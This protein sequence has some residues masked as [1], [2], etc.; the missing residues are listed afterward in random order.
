M[1]LPS[2]RYISQHCDSDQSV[3]QQFFCCVEDGCYILRVS[4]VGFISSESARWRFVGPPLD[5]R[6][7]CFVVCTLSI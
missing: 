4:G 1:L 6:S 5:T 2:N 3:K 7:I